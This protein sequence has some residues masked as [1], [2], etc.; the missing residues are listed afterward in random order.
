M[1]RNSKEI[2]NDYQKKEQEDAQLKIIQQE[3]MASIGQLAAGVAHEINNPMAYIIS[4]L[5]SLQKYCDNISQFMSIHKEV[6][7]SLKKPEN[8]QLFSKVNEANAQLKINFV[9]QDMNDLIDETLSGARRVKNIVQD[10]KG[11]A[12]METEVCLADINEGIESTLN[13]I[14]NEIKYKAEIKKDL[15]DIPLTKCNIG[16]INQVFMNILVNAAQAI[17]TRGEIFIKTQADKKNIFVFISDTGKGMPLEV[18]NKIFEPF[19]TTKELGKGTGLGL[20]VT[21]DIIKK[22]D[23]DIKVESEIGKGT[24]FAITLP[25]INDPN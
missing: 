17:E 18:M 15:G 3:K 1:E 4:N 7:A 6:L 10:L 9:M 21:Y 22:H 8:D 2:L 19:F 16:Q 20:S 24:T 5:Q 11:F 25:I 14:W 12:R 13:I 23:G